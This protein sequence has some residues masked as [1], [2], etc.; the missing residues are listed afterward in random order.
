[1]VAA[2]VPLAVLPTMLVAGMA[3]LAVVL[4][5]L[6][7]VVLEILH[8]HH[9]RR[10]LMVETHLHLL[11]LITQMSVVVQVVVAQVL[12]AGIFLLLLTPQEL[13]VQEDHQILL[14]HQ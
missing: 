12:S 14:D 5:G 6:E 8:Q 9:Q 7:S 4:L 11:F 3:V 2:A 1:V 13:V 10:D